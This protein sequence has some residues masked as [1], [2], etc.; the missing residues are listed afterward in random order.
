VAVT[1]VKGV[2][3]Y[4]ATQG[5]ER[6]RSQRHVLARAFRERHGSALTD[7]VS[8]AV[9]YFIGAWDTVAALGANWVTKIALLAIGASILAIVNTLAIWAAGSAGPSVAALNWFLPAL[10]LIFGVL[11]VWYLVEHIKFSFHTGVP[12]YKTLHM[13]GW[14]MAFHDRYLRGRETLARH[15][16]SIDEYRKQFD[17]VPWRVEL[18][19]TEDVGSDGLVEMW[20]AGNHEDVGGGYSEN[21]SRLSDI[22][23]DWMVREAKATKFPI[24]TDDSFLQLHP[25]SGGMQHDESRVGLGWF[26]LLRWKRGLRTVP[27]DATFHASVVERFRCGRVLDYDIYGAYRPDPLSDFVKFAEFYDNGSEPG[28]LHDIAVN[29]LPPATSV[30]A[31]GS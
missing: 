2:Y 11:L 19:P 24:L 8:N 9:P 16:L 15:A 25:S 23:L 1:A 7:D 26:G 6:F 17:R 28:A 5:A 29:N 30:S 3:V 14:R 18:S 21:E 27:K 20:F 4:G 13:I 31:I 22:A 12:V 10:P